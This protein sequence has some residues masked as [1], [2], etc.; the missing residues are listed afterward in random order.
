MK[1]NYHTMLSYTELHKKNKAEYEA[2]KALSKEKKEKYHDRLKPSFLSYLK[3]GSI[4]T[5]TEYYHDIVTDNGRPDYKTIEVLCLMDWH[6]NNDKDGFVIYNGY[7]VK[8]LDEGM[9]INIDFLLK[10]GSNLDS[11]LLFFFISRAYKEEFPSVKSSYT[12]LKEFFNEIDDHIKHALVSLQNLN[13][14][15]FSKKNNN[16]IVIHLN[17][18]NI[19]KIENNYSN[20]EQDIAINN[21]YK[22]RI[23]EIPTCSHCLKEL[24]YQDIKYIIENYDE[25]Y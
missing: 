9:P 24:S 10:L 6:G 4:N 12:E 3:M 22:E 14:I 1:N 20:L 5:F 23:V 8:L 13:L 16:D 7:K 21:H 18:N 2:Y 19:L 17:K 25:Y 15:T 11:H